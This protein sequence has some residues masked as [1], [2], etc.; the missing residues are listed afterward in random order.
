[1]TPS[2]TSWSRTGCSTA[3]RP[4]ARCARAG[5]PPQPAGRRPD[6]RRPRVARP[7]AAADPAAPARRA[8]AGSQGAALHVK[9]LAQ[10]KAH[11]EPGR[12][13]RDSAL[14][15]PRPPGGR[16]GDLGE[17]LL[18]HRASCGAASPTL[19]T[20]AP[21][22]PYTRANACRTAGCS[23]TSTFRPSSGAACR[24]AKPAATSRST[25]AVAA[26]LDSPSRAARTPRQRAALEQVE[27]SQVRAADAQG[28]C[29]GVVE[30]LERP[31]R[32]RTAPSSGC[33]SSHQSR[34]A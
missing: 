12:W 21:H 18:G 9:D 2:S 5:L 34:R 25:S 22:G 17:H 24:V 23:P 11:V 27:R 6:L 29:R 32:A 13:R 30:L 20:A 14:E 1:V 16:R 10:L 33:A 31:A 7:P 28:A 3:A 4:A 8:G 15:R 19:A 26:P